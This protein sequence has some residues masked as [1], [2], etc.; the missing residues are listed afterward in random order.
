MRIISTIAVLVAGCSHNVY[1]PPTRAF[2]LETPQTLDDGRYGVQLEASGHGNGPKVGAGTLR[3]RRGIA[4]G[5]EL[6]GEITYA[7]ASDPSAA[8]TNPNLLAAR[9]GAKLRSE[10][11]PEVAVMAGLGGGTFAG[12]PYVSADAGAVV[13]YDTCRLTPFVGGMGY[14]STPLDARPVDTTQPG[15]AVG[16]FVDTPETT[17]GIQVRVGLKLNLSSCDD[18]RTALVA[19]FG[20]DHF[21]DDDSDRGYASGGAALEIDLK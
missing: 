9:A 7:K 17:A 1:T 4:D 2:P 20:L 5:A 3:L 6:D 19:G 21:W 10:E 16:T 14:V 15:M 18:R 12:G 11:I 8:S 13:A